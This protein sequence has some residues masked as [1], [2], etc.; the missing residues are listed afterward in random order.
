VAKDQPVFEYVRTEGTLAGFYTP[1]FMCSLSVPGMHLHFLSSDRKTGGHLLEC[2]PSGVTAGIQFL[3]T[4][5][6]SLPMSFDYLT[7]DFRRDTEKDLESAG[8]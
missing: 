3:S 6:L 4:L 8:R 2:R 1:S 5:E 7:C